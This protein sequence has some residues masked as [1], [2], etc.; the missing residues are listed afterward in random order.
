MRKEQKENSAGQPVHS[1]KQDLIPI[2][3]RSSPAA[4]LRSRVI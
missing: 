3:I 2:G 4:W 1:G